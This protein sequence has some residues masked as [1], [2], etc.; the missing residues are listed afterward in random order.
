MAVALIHMKTPEYCTNCGSDDIAFL[1]YAFAF[2]LFVCMAFVAWACSEETLVQLDKPTRDRFRNA[3]F[4]LAALMIVA[5]VAT[6]A[7]TYILGFYD[8]R[9]FFVELGGIWTFSAY[10]LLKSYELSLSKAERMAVMGRCCRKS[11]KLSSSQNLTKI[12]F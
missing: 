2:L 3:Y 9:V 4:T 7:M 10:W 12:G 5:P 1:H 6:V 8:R 11:R